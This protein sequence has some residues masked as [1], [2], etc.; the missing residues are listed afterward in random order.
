MSTLAT[1]GLHSGLPRVA[2]PK[3]SRLTPWV[4][5]QHAALLLLLLCLFD[6]LQTDFKGACDYLLCWSVKCC[7]CQ[8]QSV[9]AICSSYY[10]IHL[11]AIMTLIPIYNWYNTFPNNSTYTWFHLCH[12]ACALL[13]CSVLLATSY[14]TRSVSEAEWLMLLSCSECVYF[15]I[16]PWFL[17]I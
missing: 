1:V 14:P 17:R 2:P 6:G 16:L 5:Q 13:F 9:N 8:S 15:L 12:L 10:R 4:W 7:A 11:T 3:C